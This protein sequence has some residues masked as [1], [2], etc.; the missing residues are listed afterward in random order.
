[1]DFEYVYIVLSENCYRLANWVIQSLLH[2]F[3]YKL[4]LFFYILL[5]SLVMK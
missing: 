4:Y 5:F 3:I 1:M 2:V